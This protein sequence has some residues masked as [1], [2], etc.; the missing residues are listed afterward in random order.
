MRSGVQRQMSRFPLR[1]ESETALRLSSKHK[2]LL[3]FRSTIVHLRCFLSDSAHLSCSIRLTCSNSVMANFWWGM[4]REAVQTSSLLSSAMW[5][6]IL[7]RMFS[8]GNAQDSWVRPIGASQ[9]DG[10]QWP[11]LTKHSAASS[12][13]PSWNLCSPWKVLARALRSASDGSTFSL[14]YWNWVKMLW[15]GRERCNEGKRGRGLLQWDRTVLTFRAQKM[16]ESPIHL[17]VVSWRTLRRKMS[18]CH[19]TWGAQTH[20]GQT[21]HRLNPPQ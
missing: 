15:G 16:Q 13:M 5:K 20:E 18:R 9:S 19:K 8:C 7:I 11:A 17:W 21:N 3:C 14:L 4:Q 12:M 6:W 2:S 1:L 10:F